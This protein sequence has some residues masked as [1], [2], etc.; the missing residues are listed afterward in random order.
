M[1][2]LP[3]PLKL[4]TESPHP[5]TTRHKTGRG[6][7][8]P[9][10][11]MADGT[12]YVV[13]SSD[14]INRTIRE[15]VSQGQRAFEIDG[16]SGQDI[17]AAGLEGD[18]SIRLEG[19]V[20]ARFGALNRGARLELDGNAGDL[21]GTSQISGELAINGD[22]GRGFG[23]AARGG[24]MVL[25]GNAG[26]EACSLFQG[27]EAWIAGNVGRDCARGIR[28]G[29]VVIAGDAGPGLGYRMAGGTVF[30]GGKITG[31]PD[32]LDTDTL[33]S[34]EIALVTEGL[35]HLG[36]ET[37]GSSFRKI[38]LS[39]KRKTRPRKKKTPTRTDTAAMKATKEASK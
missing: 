21:T 34:E 3:G 4:L 25:S 15:T 14:E 33:T 26:D 30:V 2:T 9:G 1:T 22:V 23:L 6:I 38:V 24:L 17:V 28:D 32:G 10:Y 13:Q 20:G 7:V 12:D 31:L 18:I 16:L 35:G 5:H 29:M 36:V 19:D 11:Q 8:W 39:T 27:A 37:D